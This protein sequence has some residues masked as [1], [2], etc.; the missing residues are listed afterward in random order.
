MTNVL[1][2]IKSIFSR[3]SKEVTICKEV[4]W[5]ENGKTYHTDKDCVS[6]KKSKDIKYGTIDESGKTTKCCNCIK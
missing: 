2:K 4:Y 1:K 3:D 5:V 6:L